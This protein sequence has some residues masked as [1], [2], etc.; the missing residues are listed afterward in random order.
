M[1]IFF[2]GVGDLQ[3]RQT[4]E[5]GINLA[6]PGLVVQHGIW[7]PLHDHAPFFYLDMKWVKLLLLVIVIIII[8]YNC[9]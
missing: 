4:G 7:Y 5:V 8:C 1:T 9:L 2:S 6:T 3:S